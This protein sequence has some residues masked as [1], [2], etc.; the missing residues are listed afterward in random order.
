MIKGKLSRYKKILL[1]TLKIAVCLLTICG[2]LSFLNKMYV[3]EEEL[4]RVTYHEFYQQDSVDTLFLGS[5]HVFCGVVPQLVDAYCGVNSYSL[6]TSSQILRTS[7]ENLVEACREYNIKN[8]YVD[9]YYLLATGEYDY[10]NSLND[11][12]Y[13][14]WP[15]WKLS[16]T[17]IKTLFDVKDNDKRIE[18]LFPFIRFRDHTFDSDWINYH[19]ELKNSSD[20]RSYIYSKN[21]ANGEK[22]LYGGK[23]AIL[24]VTRYGDKRKLYRRDRKPEEMLLGDNTKKVLSC[25][26]N[27]CRDND[28]KL[29]FI[30]VPMYEEQLASVDYDSFYNSVREFIAEQ[31]VEFWDFNLCKGEYLPIQNPDYFLDAG[32]LNTYGANVFDEVLCRVIMGTPAQYQDMFYDSYE[33]KM[34]MESPKTYGMYS[35]GISKNETKMNALQIVASQPEK[36]E[37]KLGLEQVDED[38]KVLEYIELQDW[39][40]NTYFELDAEEMGMLYLDWRYKGMRDTEE[41]IVIP[42]LIDE[43]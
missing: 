23:G 3:D 20:Y 42:Y 41:T 12:S 18:A 37:Y 9:V 38:N 22:E 21:H 13:S 35:Y 26:V 25:I 16:S 24:T 14:N 6:A 36:M 31:N 34:K 5:S 43:D 28:I 33:E 11:I 8:V 19:V 1:R 40:E 17:K 27:F 32:H 4:S 29:T 7:Y 30:T 2:L 15:Y 10:Y 39:D